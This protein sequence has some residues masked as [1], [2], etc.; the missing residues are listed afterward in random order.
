MELDGAALRHLET[1]HN[2]CIAIYHRFIDL[3]YFT[4]RNK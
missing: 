2:I 3:F 4:K 1:N